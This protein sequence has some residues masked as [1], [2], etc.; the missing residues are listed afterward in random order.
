MSRT[1]TVFSV[2]LAAL[3]EK[4]CPRNCVGK[5]HLETAKD[6]KH[7]TVETVC[8]F[9]H[10]DEQPYLPLTLDN[11]LKSPYRGQSF[12]HEHCEIGE[13]WE[14]DVWEDDEELP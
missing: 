10:T 4:Y 14:P 2:G 12:R 3:P 1:G 11:G 7:F 9:Y 6:G 8:C 5:Q 13:I